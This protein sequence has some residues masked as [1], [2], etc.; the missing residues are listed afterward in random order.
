MTDAM[1]RFALRFQGPI[2]PTGSLD[3]QALI[4]RS[5]AGGEAIR[6]EVHTIVGEVRRW[7]DA[8]L[9]SYAERFDRVSLAELEVPRSYWREALAGLPPAVRHAFDRAAAN[10]ERAHRAFKPTAM[11]VETEPGV[12]IERRPD[13]IERVGVYVPGGKAAYPSSVLMS[14]I[15]ARIA[16]VG[17]ILVASPPGPSGRP[18]DL[19]LAACELARADRVFAIGGAGAIAALAFGTT[20][21]PR[22][23]KI[24]GPGNAYVMEAKLQV[25]DR[26][27]IDAPAGP[28]EIMILAD[29]SAPLELLAIELVAQAEHDPRS[30]V[31]TV[32]VG[33]ETRAAE[34]ARVVA[35]VVVESERRATVEAAFS[36]AGGI[37]TTPSL[38]AAIRFATDYAPEHLLLA[39]ADPDQV[40][41]RLK[42]A[43]AVFIGLSSSVVFG[44][45]L[46]GGNHVLPT[47]GL[48]RAYSGLSTADFMRWTTYQ[49]V[50]ARAAGL[51]A[52]DTAVFARAEGLP[53]HAVAAEHRRS[54]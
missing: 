18:H 49:T 8:A 53:S 30:P 52:A 54:Q 44:D 36:S 37:L 5:I 16:G 50:T 13:P 26:V 19:V 23:D 45:Y 35:S 25:A 6:A 24:V 28:S 32:L 46:T 4:E 17:Q 11:T 40:A 48:A 42:N 10:L 7:G 33:D 20:T 47:G 39:V 1:T 29:H 2:P 41:P 3:Y 34:L 12:T 51:L 15:P 14:V 9:V 21:V 31:V 43:G 38:D 22:V 27:A